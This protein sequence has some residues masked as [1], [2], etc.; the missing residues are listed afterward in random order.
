MTPGDADVR[1]EREGAASAV[2]P[3]FGL[4][5]WTGET[6]PGPWQASGAGD[7]SRMETMVSTWHQDDEGRDICVEVH[8]QGEHAKEVTPSRARAAS[9]SAWRYVQ[10]IP[11]ADRTSLVDQLLAEIDG[12]ERTWDPITIEVDG[13]ETAFTLLHFSD[14]YWTAVGH[15]HEVAF[16][17][18][19]SG[20]PLPEV[21]VLRLP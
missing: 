12:G 9:N 16:T 21:S 14:R 19:S 6:H 5:G 11:G 18:T 15:S 10:T 1:P 4:P 2:L 17:I 3:R 8:R 20:V 13:V 7:D